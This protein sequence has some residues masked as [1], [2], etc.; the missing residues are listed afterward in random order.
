MTHEPQGPSPLGQS[1]VESAAAGE[2]ERERG[3]SAAEKPNLD[4]REERIRTE[5]KPPGPPL[6]EEEGEESAEE[7]Q[8]PDVDPEDE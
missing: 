8:P 7:E 5:R 3:E 1:D 4:E 6:P 2:P